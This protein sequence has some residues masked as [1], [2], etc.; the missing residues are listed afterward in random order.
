M[1]D[2]TRFVPD[3]RERMNALRKLGDALLAR[4]VPEAQAEAVT[5]GTACPSYKDYQC[6]TFRLHERCCYRAKPPY[7]SRA[8]CGPW[9]YTGSFC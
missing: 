9:E 3:G 1:I 6:F 4:L 7:C 5:C 2:F 8:Y